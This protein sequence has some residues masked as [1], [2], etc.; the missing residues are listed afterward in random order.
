MLFRIFPFVLRPRLLSI[1][2]RWRKKLSLTSLATRDL[3]IILIIFFITSSIYNGTHHALSILHNRYHVDPHYL[4]PLFSVALLVLFLLLLFSSCSYTISSL[5]L[6][7]DI[8]LILASPTYKKSFFRGKFLEIFIHSSWIVII[9]MVPTILAFKSSYNLGSTFYLVCLLALVPYFMLPTAIAI[10]LMTLLTRFVPAQQPKA[11]LPVLTLLIAAPILYASQGYIF[12]SGHNNL[13]QIAVASSQLMIA[14]STIMPSWW[15]AS[16]ISL[17]PYLDYQQITIYVAG[18]WTLFFITLLVAK[19]LHSKL[20]LT[21]LN[22]SKSRAVQGRIYSLSSSRKQRLAFPLFDLP[23][24]AIAIK[25][26]KLFA[27]DITHTLQLSLL[28]GICL[29]YLYNFRMIGQAQAL[30]S[31]PQV[32]WHTVLFLSNLAMGSFVITALSTRFVFPS[33]SLEGRSIWLLQT[34]PLSLKHIL[35]AKFFAWIL[36]VSIIASVVL[37][38]GC[39]AIQAPLKLVFLTFLIS[40]ISC[41]GIVG[42]SVGMGAIFSNF[43]WEHASQ[44]SASV[45]SLVYMSVST[46]LIL[47]NLVPVSY[48]LFLDVSTMLGIGLTNFEYCTGYVCSLTLLAYI[49][50]V[51]ARKALLVGEQ[52]LERSLQGN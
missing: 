31:T 9:C 30:S 41:Y 37:C 34:S 23:T 29:L 46:L 14:S 1:K 45:G 27:R 26:F 6:A 15:A 7:E 50:V 38:S 2:N 42:L 22:L 36:P 19:I 39:L 21:C 44:L 18:L 10:G 32:A 40:F 52:A 4:T 11:I 5:F 28:I 47:I 12:T 25:E 51:V 3:A 20:N 17:W 48:I 13:S 35:R 49:N 16:L 33:V 8:D 43:I 24:R